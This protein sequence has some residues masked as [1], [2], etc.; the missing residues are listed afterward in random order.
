MT[1][2]H[3][4]ASIYFFFENIKSM[5]EF[6]TF[7]KLLYKIDAKRSFMRKDLLNGY[8]FIFARRGCSY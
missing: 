1:S 4:H 2:I 8:F 3:V 5:F 7:K 6:K